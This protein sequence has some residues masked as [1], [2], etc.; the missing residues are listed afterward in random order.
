MEKT[1][2]AL[3]KKVLMLEDDEEISLERRGLLF[4]KK[5][6]GEESYN[7]VGDG[8]KSMTSVILDF[9]S[10]NL[11]YREDEDFDLNNLSGIFIVDE[12]E[13]HLH[14]KWQTEG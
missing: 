5:N 1:A 6:R 10:W 14:P 2:E 13:Q 9:L 12:L 4:V 8:Y 3:L 11:I 7:N